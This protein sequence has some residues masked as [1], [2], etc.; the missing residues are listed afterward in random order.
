[1]KVSDKDLSKDAMKERRRI[2]DKLTE[3]KE[4]QRRDMQ[5]IDN[6]LST[7]KSDVS[8]MALDTDTRNFVKNTVATEW[9]P[10]IARCK[11]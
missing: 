4:L 9:G 11:E 10:L 2:D 6:K 1:M 5:D 7:F 3:L 8:M